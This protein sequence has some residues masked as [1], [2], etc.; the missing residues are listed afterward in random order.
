M[1]R[2]YDIRETT[3]AFERVL[4]RPRQASVT[5]A[6]HP[7][8]DRRLLARVERRRPAVPDDDAGA[9]EAVSHFASSPPAPIRALPADDIVDGIAGHARSCRCDE[10]HRASCARR[11]DDRAV[12]CLAIS[13]SFDVVHLHGFSQKS[14][15]LVLLARLFR[16][17][18]V[19]T[20]HTAEQDEP[21]GVRR[22]GA[23]AYRRYASAD[24]FIAISP[25]LAENYRRA[26]LPD[27]SSRR[28]AERR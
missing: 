2:A 5:A 14:V 23:F 24:R 18:V 20:I 25:R 4:D 3:A 13:R 8:G 22:L 16:K 17:K 26:G 19:I 6:R 21:E 27:R 15:L 7:D 11:S 9:C 1:A 28:R 10:R 12:L